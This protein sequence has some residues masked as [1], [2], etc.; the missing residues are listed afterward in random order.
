MAIPDT[1]KALVTGLLE[2]DFDVAYAYRPLHFDGI[3][4]A[5]LNAILYLTSIAPG[6]RIR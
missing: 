4:H 5:F 1:A 2:D 6:F 3:A